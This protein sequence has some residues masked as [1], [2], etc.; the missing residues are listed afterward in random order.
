MRICGIEALCEDDEVVV[1]FSCLISGD[2]GPKPD[3]AID[4]FIS[5]ELRVL[6]VGDGREPIGDICKNKWG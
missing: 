5:V 3:E 2:A 1:V 4:E 6:L